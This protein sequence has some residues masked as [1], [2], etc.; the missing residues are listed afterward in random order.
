MSA[1]GLAECC[2]ILTKLKHQVDHCPES[3]HHKTL[4][5]QKTQC[6]RRRGAK[7]FSAVIHLQQLVHGIVYM[8]M[9]VKTSMKNWDGANK[10]KELNL[11]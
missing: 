8:A 6:A 11:K 7:Y 10:E 5:N 9:K 3:Q 1:L 2:A 4:L